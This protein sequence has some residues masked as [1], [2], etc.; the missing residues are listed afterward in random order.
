MR[1]EATHMQEINPENTSRAEAFRLWTNAPMPM[2]TCGRD[3][4][5]PK[6]RLPKKQL[7]QCGGRNTRALN[8]SKA[9]Q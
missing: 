8:R 5:R 1:N 6:A 4:R 3:T 7:F 9:M 2:V